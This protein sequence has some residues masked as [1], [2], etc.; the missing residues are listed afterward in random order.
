MRILQKLSESPLVRGAV[1]AGSIGALGLA[2][3][4]CG[5]SKEELE[6]NAKLGEVRALLTSEMG[7]M[8]SVCQT[9]MENDPSE[10]GIR[11]LK[12]RRLGREIGVAIA[13]AC[14]GGCKGYDTC[15]ECEW[16]G[17]S[18]PIDQFRRCDYRDA[19]FGALRLT[20][21]TEWESKET[22][23]TIGSVAVYDHL[24]MRDHESVVSVKVHNF[25]APKYVDKC[26]LSLDGADVGGTDN[27]E[28]VTGCRE[29]IEEARGS[30]YKI[31][32]MGVTSWVIKDEDIYDPSA[33][34][35]EQIIFPLPPRVNVT[36]E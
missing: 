32:G 6:V 7:K 26:I 24:A 36:K 35:E 31:A 25:S 29:V 14:E 28:T 5:P 9:L 13:S 3:Q 8:Q 4:G 18:E 15:G 11:E 19:G 30:L 17:P 34:E 2:V 1:V 16:E 23:S 33:T 22:V 21:R 27:A 12:V 20:T 10:G